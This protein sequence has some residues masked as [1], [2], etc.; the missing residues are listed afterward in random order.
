MLLVGLLCLPVM[1]EVTSSNGM[2]RCGVELADLRLP[3]STYPSLE[4]LVRVLKIDLGSS[5]SSLFL[6]V[7]LL[8]VLLVYHMDIFG[9][10]GKASAAVNTPA[11]S[12]LQLIRVPGMH[13]TLAS[14]RAFRAITDLS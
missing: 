14:S 12:R 3:T 11:S 6:M 7:R 9:I 13:R 1:V 2:L 8:M 10:F 4:A 5:D